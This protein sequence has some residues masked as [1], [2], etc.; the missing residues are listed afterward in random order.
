MAIKC[1][2]GQVVSA[3]DKEGIDFGGVTSC[4]TITC[5]LSDGSKVAAHDGVF[6]RVQPHIFKALKGKLT[7]R[8]VSRVIAAG[9][10]SCWTHRME[11]V[12][13]LSENFAKNDP[14]WKEKGWET[15]LSMMAPFLVS[16]S[17]DNFKQILAWQFDVSK[18]DVSFTKYDEGRIQVSAGGEVTT[19]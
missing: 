4:M 14:H 3:S 11:S 10:G 17:V 6:Q 19:G 18:S 5:C 16:K 9:S 12:A 8:K 15:Q 13:Q 7:S 2:E 1:S